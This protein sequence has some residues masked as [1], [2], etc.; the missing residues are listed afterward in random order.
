MEPPIQAH[1]ED[2]MCYPVW[3]VAAC[4]ACYSRIGKVQVLDGVGCD[5]RTS[6]CC[7]GTGIEVVWVSQRCGGFFW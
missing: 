6:Y 2:Q 5:Q 7:E 3:T 4:P 1:H